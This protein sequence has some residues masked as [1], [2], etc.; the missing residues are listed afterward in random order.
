MQTTSHLSAVAWIGQS[1]IGLN[2]VQRAWQEPKSGMATLAPPSSLASALVPAS[3][4]PA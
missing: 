1:P 3:T 4:R 2:A